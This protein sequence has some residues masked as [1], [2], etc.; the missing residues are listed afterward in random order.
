MSSLFSLLSCPGQV[1]WTNVAEH[2]IISRG[3]RPH[4]VTDGWL[5]VLGP[6]TVP[7]TYCKKERKWVNHKS[8]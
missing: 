4:H 5:S 3:G 1:L 6:A 8:G 7:D 2:I